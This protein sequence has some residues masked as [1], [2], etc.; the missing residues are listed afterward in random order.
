MPPKTKTK[1]MKRKIKYPFTAIALCCTFVF[2]VLAII[3]SAVAADNATLKLT[4]V[5]ACVKGQICTLKL[6][7][8]TGGNNVDFVRARIDFPITLLGVSE[9]KLSSAN[10]LQTETKNYDNTLGQINLGLG[11]FFGSP[12]DTELATIKFLAKQ[13]GTV[14]LKFVSETKVLSNG[15]DIIYTAPSLKLAISGSGATAP[16]VTTPSAPSTKPALPSVPVDY[17]LV[18]K[19]KGRMLLQ[20]QSVGEIWYVSPVT[21]K[22]YQAT[23]TNALPL[24][25]SLALGISNANLAKIP[26]YNA[27]TTKANWTFRAGVKGRLLLAVDDYGRVWYVHPDY[28]WRREVTKENIMTLFRAYSL[29]ITNANL[30]KIPIGN[31][32][33]SEFK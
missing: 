15:A 9:I 28:L 25:R 16:V 30:A 8:T 33:A 32:N 6:S 29:G 17:V 10:T 31:V 5:G 20:V 18:N 27:P 2:S 14:E 1:N 19:M 23:K 12:A 26:L 11:I 21:G 7:M 24:F 22:R 3:Y 13:A 4:S